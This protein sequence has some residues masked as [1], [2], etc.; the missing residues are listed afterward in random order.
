[1]RK[2]LLLITLLLGNHV[3]MNGKTF[4]KSRSTNKLTMVIGTYTGGGSKGIYTYRFDQNTGKSVPLSSVTVQNPSYLIP[5]KDERFI[6]AVS[7][8]PD[9]TAALNAYII[10][11]STGRLR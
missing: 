6:Y 4:I 11:K 2:F 1:M 5:S 3:V 9:S 10:D 8:M 7:E